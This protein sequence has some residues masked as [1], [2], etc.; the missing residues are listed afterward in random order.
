MLDVIES[1]EMNPS[2]QCEPVKG[3]RRLVWLNC[4]EESA[5]LN[6]NVLSISIAKII[7][8]LLV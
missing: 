2:P 6:G 4:V 1:A 7:S 5:A 3:Q 8:H